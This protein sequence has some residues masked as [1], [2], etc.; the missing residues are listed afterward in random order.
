MSAIE[1]FSG[2]C[3]C[4]AVRYRVE[5]SLRYPHVCH[6]RMCQKAAGN[7]FMPLAA[8]SRAKF[9]MTRGEPS[10]FQSSDDVRRGFCGRCGTPLFY[11]IPDADFINITLGSLDEP[12]RVKPEA[13]SNLGSKIHWFAELDG[14]PVEPE[15]APD[16]NR[17]P[18]NN[19]QHP[20]HD[21][22][23]WPPEGK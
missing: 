7:Y 20:D 3:Q 16:E 13:Q 21:T 17:V 2:G 22:A 23:K 9:E 11:D 1:N 15:P 8:S 18:V 12:E 10:W 19:R 5:G 4:G 14:L 6:C